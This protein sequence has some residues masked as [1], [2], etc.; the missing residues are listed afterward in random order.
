MVSFRIMM[1]N[2]TNRNST[3]TGEEVALIIRSSA[4]CKAV[5]TSEKNSLGS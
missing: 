3:Y 5:F 4:A 1:V 2:K